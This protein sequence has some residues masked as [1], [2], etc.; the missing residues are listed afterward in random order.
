VA[1]FPSNPAP[2]QGWEEYAYPDYAFS[3]ALPANPQVESD[4]TAWL[5]ISD[6]SF[7]VQ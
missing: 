1:F 2:A 5:G 7:D 3:V 4:H 6:A